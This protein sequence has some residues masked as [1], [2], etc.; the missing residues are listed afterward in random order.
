MEPPPSGEIKDDLE[1]PEW[2]EPVL[3]AF[4]EADPAMLGARIAAAEAAIVKRQRAL[5]QSGNGHPDEGHAIE[6]ALSM[7]R[8]LKREELR[9]SEGQKK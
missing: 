1:F 6:N 8:M 7:L 9:S 4:Q 3:Q 5:S 2:Q